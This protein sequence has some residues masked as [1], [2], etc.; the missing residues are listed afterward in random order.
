MIAGL[1]AHAGPR[2]TVIE[3]APWSPNDPS[4]DG[5]AELGIILRIAQ[6]QANRTVVG[7]VGVGDK[8][9][10]F[11]EGTRRGLEMAVQHGVP[12]VRL[13]RGMRACLKS[14]DKH[15]DD[16]FI[17]G[18]L[19]T[20]EAAS[21][22]LSECLARHGTLPCVRAAGTPPAAAELSLFRH[23][24]QLY[25]AEFTAHQPELVAVR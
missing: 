20:P 15:A 12:V 21:A 16:L 10:V 23:K 3:D 25:Q 2:V 17:D 1:M 5:A 18:G 11:Q 4:R 9:G 6:L 14:T 22:L 13:A 8:R 24:L 19:L 7:I